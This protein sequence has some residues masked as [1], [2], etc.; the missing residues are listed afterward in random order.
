MPA[1]VERAINSILL[2]VDGRFDADALEID[3]EPF[4]GTRA[5]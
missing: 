3:I 2:E 5:A 4:L 1:A